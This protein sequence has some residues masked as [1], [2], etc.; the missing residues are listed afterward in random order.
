MRWIALVLFACTH[1]GPRQSAPSPALELVESEPVETTLDRPELREAWQ[2]WPEMI[3]RASARL[4]FAEMYAVDEG[5]SRLTPIVEAV[6]K[7]AARGVRVRFLAAA[8]FAKTYPQVL[9]ALE[10]HGVQVRKLEKPFLHAKYFVAD[11]RE[12]YLGSQNFDWRSLQH[13]QELG[14]RFRQPEAIRELEDIFETDWIGELQ[15]PSTAY[16]FPEHTADGADVT[17]VAS[18]HGTLP[19]EKFWDLP[20]LVEIVNSARK[21]VRVQALTYSEVPDLS[22]ALLKAAACGVSVQLILSDWELRPKTLAA[23]RALDPRIEV[24][25]FTVPAASSGFIPFARVVHAKYCVVDGARGWVGTGNWEPDY[26]FKSRNVGLLIDGGQIPLQ[27]DAFF[28]GNWN[29]PYAAPFDRTREYSPPRISRAPQG[30]AALL[31][32]EG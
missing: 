15:R 5:R 16:D 25:I 26:F 32:H 10:Q 22:D 4:D 11:G 13:I 2:V 28:A 12:A 31:F 30:R 17:L 1:A 23:L 3:A 29:S 19:D 24:R 20:A 7:A 27:L 6:E 14:V 9:A 21:S 18:P 8:S